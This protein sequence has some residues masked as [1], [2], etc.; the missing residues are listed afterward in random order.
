MDVFLERFFDDKGK[1]GTF[2]AIA[3]VIFSFVAQLMEGLCKKAFGLCD[4]CAH[5][6]QVADTQW[7]MIF[8][9]ECRE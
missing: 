6:R 2:G 5:G 4:T 1:M 8:F 7:G 9:H 3:V